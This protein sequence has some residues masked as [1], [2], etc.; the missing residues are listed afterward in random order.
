MD[1]RS[2]SFFEALEE[3]DGDVDIPEEA[4]DGLQ[5]IRANAATR[6]EYDL[7]RQLPARLRE[8]RLDPASKLYR[9]GLFFDAEGHFL[10]PCVDPPTRPSHLHP[11]LQAIY[12]IVRTKVDSNF[13]FD[14]LVNPKGAVWNWI[15]YAG[16]VASFKLRVLE[17]EDDHKL[18]VP[19]LPNA[20]RMG[21]MHVRAFRAFRRN[22][23]QCPTKLAALLTE[24]AAET[25]RRNAEEARIAAKE[26][27]KRPA[28]PSATKGSLRARINNQTKSRPRMRSKRPKLAKGAKGAKS[29]EAE[30]SET[31]AEADAE[32]DSS[33]G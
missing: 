11:L 20:E 18:Y 28:T 1:R 25:V 27:S 16:A 23:R 17:D 6:E 4:V 22:D 21:S 29:A 12:G 30:V 26:A 19:S 33:D 31:D 2:T 15:D 24:Q 10:A 32:D 8:Q 13:L 7:M 14:K 5:Q 9:N 3:G